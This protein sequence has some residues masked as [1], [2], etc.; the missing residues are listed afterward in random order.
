MFLVTTMVFFLYDILVQRRQR[1]VAGKAARSTAVVASL[2]PTSVAQRL[3]QNANVTKKKNTAKTVKLGNVQPV[4]RANNPYLEA[5][6][7]DEG[8]PL[9]FGDGPGDK[10]IAELFPKATVLFAD[11]GKYLLHR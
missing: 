8:G 2:F 4:N 5:A 6:S 3:I 9:G 10:P 1:M 7:D 11:I